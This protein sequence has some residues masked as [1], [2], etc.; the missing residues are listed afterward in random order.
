[1]RTLFIV[2]IALA[3]VTIAVVASVRIPRLSGSP[4]N[5]R[6]VWRT[7]PPQ[8]R[9]LLLSD[10][11]IRTCEGLV[12][13]FSVIYAMNILRITA[14]QYG[15][16]I[17][18]QAV[19]SIVVY[20]PAAKFADRLGRKPFVVATFLAFSFFPVALVASAGFATAVIAFVIGGLREIGEPSRK[21]MIVDFAEPLLRARTVGLYYLIRSVAIAPAA[22][23]GGLLW[24]VRPALPFIVALC[25]GL[26]GTALFALSEPREDGA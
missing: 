20:I 9:R 14:P 1:M 11:F 23:I 10:I 24:G 5:I 12:D 21:A 16:L 25:A 15:I 17:A 18:I 22:F 26:A 7:F 2:T 13:E 8:L 3:A 6:G 19:T 4:S